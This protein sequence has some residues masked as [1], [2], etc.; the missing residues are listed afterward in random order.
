MQGSFENGW[1]EANKGYIERLGQI[2]AMK[3]NLPEAYRSLPFM[4]AALFWTTRRT[5]PI[6]ACKSPRV[7]ESR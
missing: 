2:K 5:L 1:V 3:E 7:G 6:Q 4:L